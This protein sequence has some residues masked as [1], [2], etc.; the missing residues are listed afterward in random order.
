MGPTMKWKSEEILDDFET[1]VPLAHVP[2]ERTAIQIETLCK[3][4]TQPSHLLQGKIAVY[5]VSHRDRLSR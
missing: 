4:H 5:V 3:P 1:V 2:I